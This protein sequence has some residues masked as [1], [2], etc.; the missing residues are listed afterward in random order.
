[1][2]A[3]PA[4]DVAPV[5]DRTGLDAGDRLGE[6][7]VAHH[8]GGD[9]RSVAHASDLRH[10]GDADELVDR[11]GPGGGALHW[12]IPSGYSTAR[13]RA[14]VWWRWALRAAAASRTPSR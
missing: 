4:L 12:D 5:E 10:L 2:V 13:S 11:A 8:P 3:Q 1:G 6:A 9:Y 7:G 14:G